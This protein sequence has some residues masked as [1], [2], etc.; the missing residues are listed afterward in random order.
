[1][2]TSRRDGSQDA[3]VNL[4]LHGRLVDLWRKIVVSVS[5]IKAV[6]PFYLIA[7][8]DS[9]CETVGGGFVTSVCT[10]SKARLKIALD[11]SSC[12]ALFNHLCICQA[13]AESAR[14]KL[15][16]GTSRMSS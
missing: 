9:G 1:M 8:C 4:P 16:V 7:A 15:F 10:L 6:S 12:S 2:T 3:F 14:L 5:R 13:A 11:T